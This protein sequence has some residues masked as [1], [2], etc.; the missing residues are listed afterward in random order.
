MRNIAIRK[1]V[2]V[3]I[4]IFTIF[5]IVVL[6]GY[7]TFPKSEPSKMVK[8]G[9]IDETNRTKKLDIYNVGRISDPDSWKNVP[10]PF[11]NIVGNFSSGPGNWSWGINW[12]MNGTASTWLLPERS[13]PYPRISINY[14]TMVVSTIRDESAGNKN[15]FFILTLDIKNHGYKYFDAHPSKFVIDKGGKK[16]YPI[17]N[18]SVDNMLDVVIPNNSRGKGDLIF[19]VGERE[20]YIGRSSIV[21]MSK[22]YTI[23]YN[24]MSS[25]EMNM[26]TRDKEETDETNE[27]DDYTD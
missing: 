1:S 25:E 24:R 16:I 17:L 7:F 8:K 2:K 5:I 6:I 15:V 11:S 20:T 23:L 14:S 21:Y 4:F 10:S 27:E 26:I 18:V 12:N 22:N 19:L 3:P 13:L 9:I